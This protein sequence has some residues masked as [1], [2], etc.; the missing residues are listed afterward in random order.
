M[1]TYLESFAL[2]SRSDEDSFVLN[3]PYQLE[4]QC[5]SHTNVYPF[6]IFPQK[7]L[8]TLSFEPITILYGGN[9][10]GKST[11]L[12]I[13]AQKLK[14]SRTAPF[15]DTPYFV[16]YLEYCEFSL[17]GALPKES[18]LIASDDVFDLLLDRRSINQKIDRKRNLLFEEYAEMRG[19]EYRFDSLSDYADLKRRNDA[20]RQTKSVYTAARLPKELNGMSNGESAFSYFTNEIKEDAL[21]LLDEPENS[22]SPKLQ[23][24]LAAFLADSARFYGCQFIISTHS[25]FLLAMK[26]AKIYDLDSVPVTSKPW[27]ELENVREYYEF[28]KMHERE[29]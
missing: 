21:Y 26:G 28:F 24:E 5:Y 13:I 14:L 1:K 17:A 25:P 29:F 19:M 8:K 6:K 15:N 9:G 7:R 16:S 4:M 23:T 11:L 10:S 3:Y 2:A 18:R 22:L 20:K 12:N 27:T